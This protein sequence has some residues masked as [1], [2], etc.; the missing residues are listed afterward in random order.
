MATMQIST[1]KENGKIYIVIDNPTKETENAVDSIFANTTINLANIFAP[2]PETD[3]KAQAEEIEQK[4]AE[5]PAP[6]A[7][8]EPAQVPEQVVKKEEKTP[9]QKNVENLTPAEAKEYL[10]EF[11][12]AI[13]KEPQMKFRPY[14]VLIAFFIFKNRLDG[15]KDVKEMG[16]NAAKIAWQERNMYKKIKEAVGFDEETVPGAANDGWV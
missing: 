2:K 13:K 9:T 12:N 6:E 14:D 10:L 3:T 8:A 7:T 15:V 4:A 11:L 5:A 16:S 1:F